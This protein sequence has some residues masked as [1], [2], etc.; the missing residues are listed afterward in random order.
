M[1]P[2]QIEEIDVGHLGRGQLDHIRPSVPGTA[3]CEG[4]ANARYG[5]RTGAAAWLCAGRCSMA[6]TYGIH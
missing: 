3:A 1:L 6:S 4:A 2:D 5:E